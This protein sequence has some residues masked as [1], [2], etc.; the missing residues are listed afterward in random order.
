MNVYP[1]TITL[2]LLFMLTM[3]AVTVSAFVPEDLERLKKR[4]TARAATS[5]QPTCV[6]LIFTMPILKGPT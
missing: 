5:V 4:K 2:S 6:A 1:A 3:T